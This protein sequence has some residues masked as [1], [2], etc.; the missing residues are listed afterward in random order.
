MTIEAAKVMVYAKAWGVTTCPLSG[1]KPWGGGSKLRSSEH[2]ADRM[3]WRPCVLRAWALR[4]FGW[5]APKKVKDIRAPM[6][7]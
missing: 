6:R 7:L 1:V 3:I 2:Q 4:E 5:C